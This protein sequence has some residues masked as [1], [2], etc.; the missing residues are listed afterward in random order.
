VAN[1]EFA[2]FVSAG[3]YVNAAFWPDTMVVDGKTVARADALRKFADRTNLPAPRFWSGGTFPEGKGRHP[4]VGVSWYEA[5]AYARWAGKRLPV[6]AEWRRAAMDTTA[7]GFP[8]GRDAKTAEARANFSQVG[9]RVV[10]SFPAGVSPFG[11]YDMAG[12]VREWLGDA[13]SASARRSVTGGSW[14]DPVYMFEPTHLEWFDP[15][16]ANEAIGFRLVASTDGSAVPEK[17]R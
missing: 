17:T 10:G 11:C 4:V 7:D 16:Y 3:G 14:L 13:Q 6:Q 12:N 8:W 1:D 5:S 9:T 2:R 15:A